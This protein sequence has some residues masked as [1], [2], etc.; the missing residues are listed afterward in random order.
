MSTKNAEVRNWLKTKIS[1]LVEQGE[2]RIIDTSHSS[3]E[4]FCLM[5][6]AMLALAACM[7]ATRWYNMPDEPPTTNLSIDQTLVHQAMS[8]DPWFDGIPEEDWQVAPAASFRYGDVKRP[9]GLFCG[10]FGVV[11][12]DGTVVVRTLSEQGDKV[13]IAICDYV[14]PEEWHG[15]AVLLDRFNP[16]V[17]MVVNAISRYAGGYASYQGNVWQWD[18]ENHK[19][20]YA[21]TGKSTPYGSEPDNGSCDFVVAL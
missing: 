12:P 17:V 7:S 11:L 19:Y 18:V 2:P 4:S 14:V 10:D 9:L 3:R 5:L 8:L 21:D 6:M 13:P 15:M 16:D 1:S 20:V